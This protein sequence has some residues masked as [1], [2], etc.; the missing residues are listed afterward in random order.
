[1]PGAGDTPGPAPAPPFATVAWQ[2]GDVTGEWVATADAV[3]LYVHGGRL[4]SG[5][6]ADVIDAARALALTTDIAPG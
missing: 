1:V 6:P 5:E 2:A 4:S 3:A